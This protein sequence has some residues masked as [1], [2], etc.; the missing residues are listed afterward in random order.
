MLLRADLL[1]QNLVQDT[2]HGKRATV[3]LNSLFRKRVEING[4][5]RIAIRPCRVLREHLG[6]RRKLLLHIGTPPIGP[7][8]HTADIITMRQNTLFLHRKR[9]LAQQKPKYRLFRQ[10]LPLQEAG[11]DA[12]RHAGSFR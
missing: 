3:K 9:Q 8:A 1:A 6:Q 12:A 11:N 2:L 10:I 4:L 5:D 7:F